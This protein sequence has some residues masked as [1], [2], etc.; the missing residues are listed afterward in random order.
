MIKVYRKPGKSNNVIVSVII[1]KEYFN[2]WEKYIF[3]NWYDYCKKYNLG[4][5]IFDNY[6]DD[7]FK[8]IKTTWHKLLIGKLISEKNLKFKINNICYLDGDIL[9]NVFGSPNIFKKHHK[10]KITVVSQY[11]NLPYS[12][13]ETQKRISFFRHNFY[14]KRY[15]LDSSL[16]MKP[17]H[18]FKFHKFKNDLKCE[19]YF[20]AGLFIFNL[21]KFNHFIQNIFYKYCRK[22]TITG[23]DEPIL[24]YEFQKLGKLNYI[25]YKYQ[26]IWVYEMANKYPFLYW[27]KDPKIQSDCVSSSLMSNFFLHFAGSW[28]EK[29]L[30]KSN[31]FFNSKKFL[32]KFFIYNKKKPRHTPRGLIRPEKS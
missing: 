1:S 26:A 11:K 6:L 30:I 4:L 32:K 22:K 15:P 5:I 7:R 2:F 23:G 19:N 3:K 12:L 21:R 25:E 24:N 29:E 18:I 14:S 20:C 31:I 10:D 8:D 28:Y 17:S 9:I 27:L 16:F 13:V